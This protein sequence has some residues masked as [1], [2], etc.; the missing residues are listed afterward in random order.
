[1]ISICEYML[2][3]FSE[4]QDLLLIGWL[5]QSNG[6]TIHIAARPTVNKQ[7]ILKIYFYIGSEILGL[8]NQV[9]V[10]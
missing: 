10:I 4:V 5:I 6:K 8:G 3:T 9:F 1:M 2:L 7:T